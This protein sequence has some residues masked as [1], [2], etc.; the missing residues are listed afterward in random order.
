MRK[1]CNPTLVSDGG[2]VAGAVAGTVAGADSSAALPLCG[3]EKKS[4]SSSSPN[5]PKGSLLLNGRFGRRAQ[6]QRFKKI[7][8]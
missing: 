3:E 4:S 7:N 6:T 8:K 1:G 5:D 2:V